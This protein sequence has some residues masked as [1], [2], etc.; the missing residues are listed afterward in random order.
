MAD[1]VGWFGESFRGLGDGAAEKSGVL[2]PDGATPNGPGGAAPGEAV[3]DQQAKLDALEVRNA[4]AQKFSNAQQDD[5]RGTEFLATVL[6]TQHLR[7]VSCSEPDAC[8]SQTLLHCSRGSR[9][10]S[11]GCVE[12][13]GGRPNQ[14]RK[15]D[16][17]V[18]H[19]HSLVVLLDSYSYCSPT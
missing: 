16:V 19:A 17:S 15:P 13:S 6:R 3:N 11:R 14:T 18:D 5:S 2:T 1:L 10:S 7:R 8:V 4:N 12:W 9:S